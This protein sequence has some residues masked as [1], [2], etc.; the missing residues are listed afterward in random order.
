MSAN[1]TPA[2]ESITDL[3]PFRFWCQKILPLVYDDSLSYYELLAK[4]VDYLNKTMEDITTLD[5]NVTNIYTAFNNLQNYVN[6]YFDTADFQAYV[7]TKLDEMSTDGTLTGLVVPLTRPIVEN[8]LAAHITEPEGVVIDSSLRITGAAADAN[9]TG[10]QIRNILGGSY[11]N[12]PNY[13]LFHG[14]VNDQG[15]ITDEPAGTRMLTKHL[16]PL[17]PGCKIGILNPSD[18]NIGHVCIIWSGNTLIEQNEIRKDTTL[19]YTGEI[20]TSN[21]WGWMAVGFSSNPVT[22]IN[23]DTFDGKVVNCTPGIEVPYYSLTY[24]SGTPTAAQTKTPVFEQGGFTTEGANTESSTAVRSMIMHALNGWV[25]C[26]KK[27][28]NN[29]GHLIYVY[30]SATFSTETLVLQQQTANEDLE[31]FLIPGNY[32][33]R[34]GYVKK[35]GSAITPAEVRNSAVIIKDYYDA[36][37]PV[38]SKTVLRNIAPFTEGNTVG[39]YINTSGGISYN[40]SFSQTDYIAVSADQKYY[41]PLAGVFVVWF[42][43]QKQ[44]IGYTDSTLTTNNQ[45]VT[46]IS[47]AAYAKF[48]YYTNTLCPNVYSTDCREQLIED[49]AIRHMTGYNFTNGVAF[50]TSIT[51][52]STGADHGSYLNYLKSKSNMII[53]VKGQGSACLYNLEG[54]TYPNIVTQIDNYNDWNNKVFCLLEGFVNDFGLSHPLG[55]YTDVAGNTSVCGALKSAITKIKA[56]KPNITLIVIFDHYGKGINA[57]DQIINGHTQYSYY[58]ELIKVCEYMGVFYIPVHKISGIGVNMPDALI[59][60]IHLT[61]MGSEIFGNVVYDALKNHFPI[62]H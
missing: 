16:I 57:Y 44:F 46:P 39:Y 42:D 34:I 45:W 5:D 12:F 2:K 61:P 48:L 14:Y 55:A 6:H 37:Y 3:S 50:G 23:P 1:F 38:A 10:N 36:L 7:D 49:S 19:I 51:S 4:V 22:V 29:I 40:E 47:G 59:D 32:F 15:T 30:N 41:I 28:D 58:E 56:A 24:P 17:Y 62:I 33:V 31:F 18:N 20:Y 13:P 21:V 27:I 25:L 35:D 52:R 43:A 9:A 53:D 60:N 26:L 54:E 8:W 11:S